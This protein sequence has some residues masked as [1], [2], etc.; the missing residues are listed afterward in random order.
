MQ[1]TAPA[2]PLRVLVVDDNRDVV[3]TLKILLELWGHAVRTAYSGTE[4]LEAASEFLPDA[5]LLD[6]QMPGM[7]GGEVAHRLRES[8]TLALTCIIVTSANA[9]DDPRLDEYRAC[10]DHYVPK[11]FNLR[12]LEEL[13]ASQVPVSP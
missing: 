2:R 13:L 4:A 3:S 1:E 5:V 8:P 7:H 12:R 6:I 10:F 9:P 11:P